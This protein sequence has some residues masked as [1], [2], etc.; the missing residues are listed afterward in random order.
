MI[1]YI[2]FTTF[3]LCCV[4]HAAQITWN[5]V[6]DTVNPTSIL[7]TGSLVEAINGTAANGIVTV[8]GVDFAASDALL[9]NNAAAVGLDG[10]TT[11]D[12]GLD[13]LLDN[14]DF[15]GGTTELITVGGGN[16]VAGQ[17]YTIQIFFTD[18]RFNRT[19]VYGDNE[20]ND[21]NVES[22]GGAGSFGQNVTGTFTADGINQTIRLATI[23]FS[24]VHITAYQIRIVAAAPTIDTFTADPPLIAS[25]ETSTLSWQI[26]GADTAVIDPG[27]GAI[28]LTSGNFEVSPATTTTYTLTATNGGGTVSSE[29][30]VG[31]DVPVLP[32]VL[33]EFLAS[34]DSVF[35][36]EDGE[37]FDWIEIY[38]PNAF[39]I[40]L[41]GYH[42]TSEFG[43]LTEWTFPSGVTLAGDSYLIV[44]ASG[45]DRGLPELHTNFRISAG[46]G[47]LALVAPDG[48][49][50]IN[51]FNYPSQR[52]DVSFSSAGFH[53]S[54]T[55]EAINGNAASGFVADT[56]FDIDRGYYDDPFTLNITTETSGASVIY[57]TDGSEPSLTNGTSS[58]DTASVLI[59]ETTI[60]R[61]AAF[62]NDLIA[63]NIDTQTYLFTADIIEQAEMDP[64]V[65]DDPAYS[66]EFA[67]A[68]QSI[69]TLSLVTE[70]DNF[71]D[72]DIGIFE[73]TQARG[74]TS[75][76]PVSLEFI[77]PSDPDASIQENAGIRIHGNGSR[78]NAKNSLRLLFRAVYGP[79][80]LEY[81]L[82]GEDFV[83][84]EFNTVVLRAQN[85]NSWTNGRAEDRR[86][87]TYLQDSFAKDTQAAMNQP[88]SGS[89]YV[90]LFLNG[91]Y[92]GVYNPTERP[93]GSFGESH[94]GGDDTD[95]D[96]VSRRFD[97]EVQS[98]TRENWDGMLTLSNTLLDSQAEYEQLQ[99]EFMDVD[100]LIDY[101][102][103]HQFM[104]TRDGPDDF[105]HNNMRLVRRN[106]P[107]GL[108][109][110]YAWDMEFSMI[111]TIGTRDYCY[112]FP[113]YSSTR[114]SNNDITDSIAS[115][116]IR[117]K[118]NNPEFQLRYADRAY[119]HL[120]NGGAL[121]PENASARFET[122]ALEIESA[123]I[124]E[125]A[126]WGDQRRAVPY[127]RDV[128]W[129][130][131]RTRVNEEFFPARPDHVVSQLRI[132]G[133]YPDIDP[134]ILSQHGGEVP[135]GFELSMTAASGVIYFTTDGSD[136]REAWSSNA[137]GTVYTGPINLNQSSTVKART[138]V[139]SE[140]SALADA[141]FLV[142]DLAD[143]SNL[144]VSEI[145]YNPLGGADLEFI[146]LQN[147]SS[148]PIDLS[149]VQFSDGI[150]F[151]FDTN[152]VLPPS[153]RILVVRNLAAFTAEYG[154]GLFIAGE[155]QN[156]TRLSNSGEQIVLL[157]ANG[158]VIQDFTY[159]DDLP[160]PT[161][162]DSDG[163]SLILVNP[164]SNPDHND[165]QSWR[166]SIEPGGN[167]AE[168]DSIEFEGGDLLTYAFGDSNPQLEVTLNG[169]ALT[170]SFV[171][172]LAADAVDLN[173]EWS[174]DL[175][176]WTILDQSFEV[177]E[178]TQLGGGQQRVS[179]SST[180]SS[181]ISEPS[182]FIRVRVDN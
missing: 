133:L 48:F 129:E 7:A 11:N 62:R 101:M 8:N 80:R 178:L 18:L 132:A 114:N 152:T 113:I 28:D 144:V 179:L 9:P 46:G 73:N 136:P 137:I 158:S 111:D 12:S 120:F 20:G 63:T 42:L 89:T 30:T 10:Q 72:G 66:G 64:D 151:A 97:V 41:D 15:G 122:R 128:E 96:A 142:G 26:T 49:P 119:K 107:A 5:S 34:N 92:W 32:P 127:T 126:R 75:E 81:P 104:Q 167:P 140:W 50:V 22:T 70:P 88:H 19:M 74:I 58:L 162:P 177:S 117:L 21:V 31:V 25:G 176:D 131:E 145:F 143:F 155:F 134:P 95:Y 166:S 43:N 3:L 148:A 98:G 57:T 116:Y 141:T 71:F 105:G 175:D 125:S 37:F 61:A 24:N 52:A 91:T 100:N 77:D 130:A 40:N 68:L 35:A 84:Q 65:V 93:D 60:I 159:S 110:A 157:A 45:E 4:T 102:L 164:T 160:W 83:A 90:H 172:L 36:D 59:D 147:I 99:E 79:R 146:E 174:S 156:E 115:V 108:W 150:D 153:S 168:T 33:N 82:F 2:T 180:T 139:G 171:H 6:E 53:V 169:G 47:Y 124:V 1:R 38:N 67:S 170:F 123:V 135:S 27:V 109:Q 173:L 94:F 54:P 51:E 181:L 76:R 44:F 87:T 29:I 85:A 17:T 138:L 55:P 182:V 149:G 121:T 163:H 154:A 165:P 56:S 69:R 106:N 118:D 78:G 103:M 112:P 16:L 23:G 39:A 13:A 14:V 161:A 86:S